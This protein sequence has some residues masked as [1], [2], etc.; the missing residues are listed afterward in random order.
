MAT[1]ARERIPEGVVH[2]RGATSTGF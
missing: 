1:F 2:A